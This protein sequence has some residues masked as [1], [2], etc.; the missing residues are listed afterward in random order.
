MYVIQLESNYFL[1]SNLEN[2][3][4]LLPN[5]WLNLLYDQQ[6]AQE[7]PLHESIYKTKIKIQ[8]SSLL[9]SGYIGFNFAKEQN[10]TY[11]NLISSEVFKISVVSGS[12]L[13]TLLVNFLRHRSALADIFEQSRVLSN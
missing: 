11:L 1:N 6:H 5:F 9:A 13:I 3:Q 4:H 10:L 12:T 2:H 7:L 8:N